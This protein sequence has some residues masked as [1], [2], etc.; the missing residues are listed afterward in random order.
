MHPAKKTIEAYKCSFCEQHFTDSCLRYRPGLQY[1]MNLHGG[2]AFKHTEVLLYM[3]I[4][5]NQ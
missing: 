3:P 4:E 2:T 1:S 5:S